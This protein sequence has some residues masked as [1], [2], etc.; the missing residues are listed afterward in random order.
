MA[1]LIP[2]K[3]A[4]SGRVVDRF[5]LSAAQIAAKAVTLSQAPEDSDSVVVDI[6]EGTIQKLTTDYIV[7]GLVVSW[8][9]KGMETILIENDKLIITYS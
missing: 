5:T 3:K 7:T 4:E 6:P 1:V 8:D 9:G 2:R